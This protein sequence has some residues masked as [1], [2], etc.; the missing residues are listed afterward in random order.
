MR[1]EPEASQLYRVVVRYE[2]V[3]GSGR[4]DSHRSRAVLLRV[5]HLLIE[6][7]LHHC[8]ASC[9]PFTTVAVRRNLF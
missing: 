6:L 4:R 3:L 1:H 8:V 2:Y 7:S 9:M 5:T